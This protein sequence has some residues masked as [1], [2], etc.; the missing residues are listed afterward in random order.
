MHA[1]RPPELDLEL[2]ALDGMTP[3]QLRQKYREVWGEETRSGNKRFMI[4]RIAWKLQA[5]A[6]GDLPE[7]VRQKAL[8]LARDS[9]LRTTAPRPRQGAGGSTITKSARLKSSLTPAAGTQLTRQYKGKTVVVTVLED[10]FAYQGTRYRS[11]SAAAQAITGSHV[12]GNAFFGI[13]KKRKGT[14]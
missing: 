4:K 9:D 1:T 8:A 10:G 6:E 3:K 12:S 13:T 11:L 14:P 5:N 7:R 2:S